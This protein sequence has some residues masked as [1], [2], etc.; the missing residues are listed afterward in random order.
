M[1]ITRTDNREALAN[2]NKALKKA[3]ESSSKEIFLSK[4]NYVLCIKIEGEAIPKRKWKQHLNS[5][6]FDMK[7][8]KRKC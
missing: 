2:A 1:I 8:Y 7:E 5:H 4:D 3:K 6:I